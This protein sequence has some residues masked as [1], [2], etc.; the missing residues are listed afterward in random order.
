MRLPL[1]CTTSQD[2]R[3]AR[4]SCWDG[5]H[6][7][8]KICPCLLCFCCLRRRKGV[9]TDAQS[10]AVAMSGQFVARTVLDAC[11]RTRRSKSSWLG[12]SWSRRLLGTLQRPACTR[13][14]TVTFYLSRQ[15]FWA[16]HAADSW[17]DTVTFGCCV[18]TTSDNCQ[19]TRLALHNDAADCSPQNGLYYVEKREVIRRFLDW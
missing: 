17:R 2:G 11:R 14:C 13:R 1:C 6:Q 15:C 7:R 10:T 3:L 19:Q 4:I 16:D 5:R 9:T 8:M 18:S 12:T